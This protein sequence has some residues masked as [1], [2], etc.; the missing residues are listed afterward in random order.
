M[1]ASDKRMLVDEDGM[2]RIAIDGD[3]AVVVP[4]AFRPKVLEHVHGS[5]L[6]GHYRSRRTFAGRYWW[7]GWM[8]DVV[9][10]IP[11]CLPCTEGEDVR[12]RQQVP[13]EVIHPRGRFEQV[14]V[15]VQTVKPRTAAVKMKVLAMVDVL[16]PDEKSET[17]IRVIVD[18]WI[19][20]FGPMVRLLSDRGPNLIGKIV[21]ERD[22]ASFMSTGAVAGMSTLLW[23]ASATFAVFV[24]RLE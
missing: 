24:R 8:R 10:S 7:K 5:A 23:Q 15:D 20:I 18:E 6:T 2:L 12:P 17:I 16:I 1:L 11:K 21:E 19:S 4:R 9:D 3:L 13:F 14:E 22:L